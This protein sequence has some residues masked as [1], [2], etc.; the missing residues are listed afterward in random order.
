MTLSRARTLWDLYDDGRQSLSVSCKKC[1]WSESYAMDQ[2][3]E[4]YGK[5]HRVLGVLVNLTRECPKR[6]RN[7]DKDACGAAFVE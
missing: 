6:H 5:R 7:P 3:I 2:L 1:P 4:D